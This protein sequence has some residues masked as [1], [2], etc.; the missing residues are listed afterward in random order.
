MHT[1][2]NRTIVFNK[3][4]RI[5]EADISDA[6]HNTYKRERINREDAVAVLVWNTET[7]K[8]ILTR[9]FRYAVYDK[10]NENMIEVLAGKIEEEEPLQTAIRETE[11]EIGYR[12]KPENIR[13]LA[14]CFPTPGYSTER[15]FIYSATV[16]NADQ[17]SEGGG[18][19]E[20]HEDI[21]I[22][23]LVPEEF[24]RMLDAGEIMDAKTYIAGL[25][26][27]RHVAV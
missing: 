8:V 2:S 7:N 27:A 17:V 14:T 9:Q 13:L 5:E 18:L 10:L 22:V 21:E 24:Y 12:L 23:E 25:L 26:T 6:E 1:V 4:L 11:E 3:H 16:T 20:E 19:K 15:Y